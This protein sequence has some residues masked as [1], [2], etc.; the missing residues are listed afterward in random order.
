MESTNPET[1]TATD[2][3]CG[4]QVETTTAQHTAEHGGQTYF[5]CARGCQLDFEEDPQRYLD[6]GYVPSM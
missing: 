3:V 2:P 1:T 6:P 4:M 5:F